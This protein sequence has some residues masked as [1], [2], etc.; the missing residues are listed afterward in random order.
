MSL[1]KIIEWRDGLLAAKEIIAAGDA[2]LWWVDLRI[3]EAEAKKITPYLT[4][5]QK[6]KLKRL[7][8]NQKKMSYIAGRGFLRALLLAYTNEQSIELEYNQYGKPQL[9]L[10]PLKIVFNYS[11]TLGRGVFCIARDCEIGIDL[12]STDRQGKFERIVERRFSVEEQAHLSQF[13]GNQHESFRQFLR[14]WTRKEAYGKAVGVG[15]NYRLR[16]YNFCTKDDATEMVYSN[17]AE[18]WCFQQF[19]LED[20]AVEFILCLVNSGDLPKKVIARRFVGQAS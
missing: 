19:I 5:K 13:S 12:E 8:S 3:S 11:D 1:G 17:T 4:D 18:N 15:L 14:Y 9:L 20:D 7:P 2:H 10:N 6:N 16:D